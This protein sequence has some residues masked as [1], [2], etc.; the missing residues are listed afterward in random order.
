MYLLSV[1][2][3]VFTVNVFTESL[4]YKTIYLFFKMKLNDDTTN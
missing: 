4:L 2:V 1:F 3:N